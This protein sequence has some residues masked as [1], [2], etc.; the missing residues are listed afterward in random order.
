ME[1]VHNTNREPERSRVYQLVLNVRK[2]ALV[3]P[4]LLKCLH[5]ATVETAV[6]TAGQ[7]TDPVNIVGTLLKTPQEKGRQLLSR[8]SVE[9]SV[10][11]KR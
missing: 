7:S 11:R 8:L 9:S 4:R 10:E 1:W 6:V 5:L 3:D 2:M